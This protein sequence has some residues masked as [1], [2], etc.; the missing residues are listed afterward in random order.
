MMGLSDQEF[1]VTLINM[2][3]DPMDKVDYMQEQNKEAS[4]V[5]REVEILKK[6]K[7]EMLEFNTVTK[8]RNTFE[9]LM[10]ALDMVEERSLSLRIC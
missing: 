8:I 9:K 5:S 10:R 2:L 7:K 4:N 3:R 6:N 1:K